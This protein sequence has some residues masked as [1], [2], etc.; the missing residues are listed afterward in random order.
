MNIPYDLLESDN[1]N[2]S[3]SEVA[4]EMLNKTIIKPLQQTFVRQ[5]KEQLRPIFNDM[6]DRIALIEP[7]TKNQKEEMEVWT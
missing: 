5:I 4:F 2:R 1:S 3:S 7:D 6:V